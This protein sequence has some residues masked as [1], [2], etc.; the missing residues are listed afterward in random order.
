MELAV[1]FL[2]DLFTVDEIES[3][4]HMLQHFR[5]ALEMVVVIAK[6]IVDGLRAELPSLETPVDG[7]PAVF[8]PVEDEGQIAEP[9]IQVSVE[10]PISLNRLGRPC[11]GLRGKG[12]KNR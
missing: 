5:N 11:Q 10:L 1:L 12:A 2:R 6:V 9:G 8:K 3:G 4:A 7:D